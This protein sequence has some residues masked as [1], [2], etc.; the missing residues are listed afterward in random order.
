MQPLPTLPWCDSSPLDLTTPNNR[1]L[2]SPTWGPKL[3]WRHIVVQIG[4]EQAWAPALAPSTPAHDMWYSAIFQVLGTWTR[5]DLI[6][7]WLSDHGHVCCPLFSY[8]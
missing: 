6:S 1:G 3:P 2:H 8:R 7:G 4:K 5:T